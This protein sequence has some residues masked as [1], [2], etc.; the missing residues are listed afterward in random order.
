MR[1]FAGVITTTRRV[2]VIGNERIRKLLLEGIIY[3]PM[4]CFL[5]DENAARVMIHKLELSL[6]WRIILKLYRTPKCVAIAFL[7]TLDFSQ[8]SQTALRINVNNFLSTCANRVSAET[9]PL[10]HGHT[11]WFAAD[12]TETMRIMGLPCSVTALTIPILISCKAEVELLYTDRPVF[13]L[14][15]FFQPY[16]TTVRV[17][18][19][20]HD[21]GSNQCLWRHKA[22]V[23]RLLSW[24]PKMQAMQ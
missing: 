13:A 15:T 22:L 21:Y 7:T 4:A 6:I 5:A 14:F 3:I 18:W 8:G 12:T 19:W 11:R 16:Q 9:Y 1:L 20:R 24:P 23:I 2:G 17:A 10:T